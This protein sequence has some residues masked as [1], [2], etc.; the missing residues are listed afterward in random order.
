MADNH[1]LP[2]LLIPSE[3]ACHYKASVLPR[4][5]RSGGS[6][7]LRWLKTVSITFQDLEF[8]GSL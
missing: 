3:P 5:F 8:D 6:P 4:Y 1:S 2:D 7:G